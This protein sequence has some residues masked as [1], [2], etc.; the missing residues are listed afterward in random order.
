MD[1]TS[2]TTAREMRLDRILGRR[3]LTA[4]NRSLGRVEEFRAEKRDSGYLIM[5][6]VI[7]AAGLMERLGVGFRLLFGRTSAGYVVRWDQ[8]ELSETGDL[9]LNCSVEELRE[10]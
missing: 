5:E 10:L 2:P 4:N 3:V 7:G 9:R 6:Y 1:D 8:L